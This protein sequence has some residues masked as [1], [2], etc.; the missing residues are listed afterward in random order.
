VTPTPNPGAALL[1]ST[2][3]GIGRAFTQKSTK[4]TWLIDLDFKPTPDIL[5]Y[6]KY[7]RG[8]RAGGI[9]EANV[10]AE[11]WAP[12]TVDD[13]E[14]GLKTS[15]RGSGVR[16]YFNLGGYWNEFRNQQATVVIPQCVVASRPTCTAPAP[17]GINGI[18]N[19]SKSRL[20]GIEADG[21]VEFGDFRLDFGYAYLDAK[22]TGGSTPFCDNTRYECAQASFLTTGSVLPYAAKNRVTI[23][24][25]YTL[26]I[27][28]SVGRVSF[29]ATFTH[30]D[31]QKTTTAND[32]AFSVGAIPYNGGISPATDLLN[33]NLNW[34]NVGGH[35]IDLALFA[36][37]VTDQKYWVA[38]GSALG[39]LGGESIILGTPR[40]YGARVKVRFGQ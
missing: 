31:S 20:R 36:T 9:N 24:G 3:C 27:D 34:N 5:V 40:M 8:Y 39:T 11:T 38:I 15:W 4:P 7:A 16:G 28:E 6:A 32:D 2:A 1:T 22:V 10:G 33:L 21:S 35:P 17:T 29:G 23:T 18:Q 25:T 30:T 12:E 26:P 37:N 19:V 13:Y 14:V